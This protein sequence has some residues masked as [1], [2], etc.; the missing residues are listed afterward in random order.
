METSTVD[1]LKEEIGRIRRRRRWFITLRRASLSLIV[2]ILLLAGV[3]LTEWHIGFS[4]PG[5][6]LL[7]TAVMGMAGLSAVL[8]LRAIRKLARE[9]LQ[10]A[11]YVEDHFPA[12]QQRFLTSVEYTKKGNSGVS[13]QLL[14]K[15]REDAH[16]QIRLQDLSRVTPIRTFLPAAAAAGVFLALFLFALFSSTGWMAANQ[17]ILWPWGGQ[18]DET[19]LSSGLAVT[20]GDVRIRRGDSV[21]IDAHIENRAARKTVLFVQNRGEDWIRIPMRKGHAD[22]RYTHTLASIQ[23]PLAYYVDTGRDRSRTF[24]ISVF[25]RLRVERIDVAY[26]FP[27]YTGLEN[28][29]ERNGGDITA[30]EGTRISLHVTFNRPVDRANLY[31][32]DGGSVDLTAEGA[33]ARGSFI[34]RTDDTYHIEAR[35]RAQLENE[36]P[37]KYF[38]QAIPDGRPEVT[39]TVPGKDRRVMPIEEVA[40]AAVARDDYGVTRFSLHYSVAGGSEKA[41]SLLPANGAGART[42]IE[43]KTLFYLEGFSVKPGDFITYYLSAADNNAAGKSVEVVSDIYFLDVVSTEEEFRKAPQ[44][45]GGG[46]GGPMRN[47]QSSA[48]VEN[49]KQIIAATWK[50]LRRQKN[51][52]GEPLEEEIQVL[53]ES[54][55]KILQRTQMS[56]RRL[57]ERLSFSD[58]SYDQ[59]VTHLTR[60]VA[61]MEDAVEKLSRQQLKEAIA[62]ETAALQAVMKAESDSRVTQVV[63]SRMRGAAGGGRPGLREREDL[64]ALFEMEMGRLENRYEMPPQADT[65]RQQAE[66]DA[67]LKKLRDLARRQERLNR[68]QRELPRGMTEAEKK[69]RLEQLRREQAQLARDSDALSKRMSLLARKYCWRQYTDRQRQMDRVTRDM[70]EAARSLLRQNSDRAEAKGREALEQLKAQE[71]A[72]QPGTLADLAEALRKEGSE[73]KAREKEIRQGLDQLIQE[74]QAAGSPKKEDLLAG[75]ETL[76]RRLEA[77]ENLLR[78]AG[79][80][81]KKERPDIT[82]KAVDTLRMVKREG[83]KARIEESQTLLKQGLLALSS[84]KEAAIEASIGRIGDRLEDFAQP[85]P[86]AANDKIGRAAADSKAMRKALE[87]LREQADAL[88]KKGASASGGRQA[89]P[90]PG[91]DVDVM[92]QGL[93]HVRRFAEGLVQP[94]AR[95]EGWFVNARS[96]HR[97][98][99]QK[100]IEDF[101][102]QPEL[103]KRLL[104]AVQELESQLHARMEADRAEKHLFFAQDEEIP[105]PYERLIEEYYRNLSRVSRGVPAEKR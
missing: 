84:E 6:I 31:L 100:E 44:Q 15:L 13:A 34:V 24:Q 51:R 65:R 74:P 68:A 71:R 90:A 32:Q 26:D 40:L 48:L 62:P 101:L 56:L 72:A 94:W 39:L 69:R 22:N 2:F 3:G 95:G 21:V 46:G 53:T 9:D 18:R 19:T 25:D 92:R 104:D 60:A 47:R 87:T 105:A 35:D 8:H 52:P 78:G 33:G 103:W 98:V 76:K 99:T 54:Q 10:L 36:N 30:P 85:S 96:I 5:R 41:V 67:V 12:L 77:V 83:V 93:S 38:I 27:R 43:G 42:T 81:W 17:R 50:L 102:K 58:P 55:K 7:W 14:E 86:G 11:H 89:H 16:A 61:H 80:Q 4:Y 66:E 29:V 59:A 20:P 64:R 37:I 88:Q 70:Q 82:D 49:Q 23:T 75:K 28:R 79:I 97:E 63:V 45:G 57:S 1:I 73:L 91:R